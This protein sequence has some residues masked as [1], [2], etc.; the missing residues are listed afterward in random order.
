MLSELK[1]QWSGTLVMIGQPAE[2]AVGGASAMLR[3]GF[4][5]DFHDPIS[6]WHFTTCPPAAG[7]VAWKEGPMLA[8]AD[9]VDILVRGFGAT[10]PPR[11]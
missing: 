11:T 10:G 5:L 3:D 1:N 6:F 2:E 8:S 9:S 4:I 7:K